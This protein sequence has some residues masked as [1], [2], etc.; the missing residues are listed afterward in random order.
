MTDCVP[1]FV[2]LLLSREYVESN[3]LLQVMIEAVD[4]EEEDAVIIVGFEVDSTHYEAYRNITHTVAKLKDAS[5]TGQATDPRKRTAATTAQ[6]PIAE[7]P[8]T[9]TIVPCAT[10]AVVPPYR[11]DSGTNA[12]R[13]LSAVDVSSAP[14]TMPYSETSSLGAQSYAMQIDPVE[15]PSKDDIVKQILSDPESWKNGAMGGMLLM[16]AK[17]TIYDMT[18]R[19]VSDSGVLDRDDLT[20]MTRVKRRQRQTRAHF[21]LGMGAARVRCD[22]QT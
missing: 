21:G 9:M 22:G 14:A 18:K 2:T 16:S 1:G 5:L 19:R 17:K 10:T 8:V 12:L 11:E 4:F 7:A 15:L 20:H 6:A 13:M 3:E